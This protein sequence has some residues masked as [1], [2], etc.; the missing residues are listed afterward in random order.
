MMELP[1]LP[2]KELQAAVTHGQHLS[3][4]GCSSADSMPGPSKATLIY[5]STRLH[6]QKATEGSA[7]RPRP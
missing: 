5:H 2:E 7:E 3:L 1:S 4:H 6:G